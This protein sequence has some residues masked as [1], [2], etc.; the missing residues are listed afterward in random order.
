MC[1][2]WSN[3]GLPR[4]IRTWQNSAIQNTSFSGLDVNMI[5]GVSEVIL[6]I[7]ALDELNTVIIVSHDIASTVAI[8]TNLWI[9]GYDYDENGVALPGARIK[10]IEELMFQ[11]IAWQYPQVIELPEFNDMVKN[12]KNA[13]AHL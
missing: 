9:L 2:Y 13:F 10:H 8:S 4:P 6:E 5:K 1:M 3:R 12:I 7:A 11:G